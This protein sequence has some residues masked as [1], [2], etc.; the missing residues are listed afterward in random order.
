MLIQEVIWLEEV[1]DKII[2]KHGVSPEAAEQILSGQPHI[3]FMER[4][5]RRDEDLYAAFG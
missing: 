5:H 2:Q 1:E 3:R 4:G